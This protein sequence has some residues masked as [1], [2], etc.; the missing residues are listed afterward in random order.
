MR[1]FIA[2][3]LAVIISIFTVGCKSSAEHIR[4][5]DE[6][7][8]RADLSEETIEWLEWYNQLTEE[9]QLSISYIPGEIHSVLYGEVRE[10]MDETADADS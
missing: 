6:T 10:G 5:H 4:F 8:K 2:G 1:K 9:E 3:L 7:F